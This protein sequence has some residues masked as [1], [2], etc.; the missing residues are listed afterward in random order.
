RCSELQSLLFDDI[1][2]ACMPRSVRVM[3]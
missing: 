2:E 3:S 1:S